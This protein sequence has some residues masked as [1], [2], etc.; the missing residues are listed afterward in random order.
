MSTTIDLEKLNKE[1]VT[2]LTPHR[3]TP[4]T[5]LI[6]DQQNET[7]IAAKNKGLAAVVV[8]YNK[9]KP[10]LNAP[11]VITF[12]RGVGSENDNIT[13]DPSILLNPSSV[14]NATVPSHAVASCV[15]IKLL[16]QGR[17]GTIVSN[18]SA[19]ISNAEVIQHR[20]NELIELVVGSGAYRASGPRIT[21]TGGVYM[22]KAGKEENLQPMVLGKNLRAAILELVDFINKLS[23]RVVEIRKDMILL[24][25]FLMAHVHISP[26]GPTT[27]SPDLAA[28]LG[29]SFIK[30]GFEVANSV[31]NTINLEIFKF[32]NLLPFSGNKILSE[33]HK[34]T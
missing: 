21:S 24:K 17:G 12:T 32:N 30:E 9:A 19:V 4:C 2:S 31:S 15:D 23:T 5:S 25:T 20:G 6:I 34:L 22:I 10:N 13:I 28:T 16:S 3:D 33:D 18:R 27:P 26:V 8:G 11:A 14:Q 1:N 7:L 29:T